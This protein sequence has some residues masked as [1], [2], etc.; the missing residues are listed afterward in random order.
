MAKVRDSLEAEF[1]EKLEW[2]RLDNRT[3]SSIAIYRVGS[4]MDAPQTE[5]IKEWAIDR[6]LQ[7]K[8]VFGPKLTELVR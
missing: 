2:E 3:A 8:A 5:E 1:G 7:F 6:L 4:I